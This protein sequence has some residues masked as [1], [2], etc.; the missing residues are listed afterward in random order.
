MSYLQFSQNR[1]FDRLEARPTGQFEPPWKS[2]KYTTWDTIQSR[3]SVPW[4]PFDRAKIEYTL[5]GTIILV[6]R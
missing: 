3:K 5:Y 1:P 6:N 4:N 2:G